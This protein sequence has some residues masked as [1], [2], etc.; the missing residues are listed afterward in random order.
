MDRARQPLL[1]ISHL[2][3]G[4]AVYNFFDAFLFKKFNDNDEEIQNDLSWQYLSQTKQTQ[5][6]RTADRII[7]QVLADSSD[8][9]D[10]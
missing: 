2:H 6:T 1:Y 7:L 10:S 4:Q 9:S 8:V 3:L 5:H